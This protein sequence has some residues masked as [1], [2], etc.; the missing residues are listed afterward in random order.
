MPVGATTL[1]GMLRQQAAETPTQAPRVLGVDEWAW[2]RGH[3]YGTILVDLE[4][5]R[6]VDLLP[7]RN[8]DTLVNWF[9]AHPGTEVVSRDRSGTFAD[10][11]RR[12][13]PDA[14]QVANRW[15]LL[16]NCSRA[17]LRRW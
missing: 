6:V 2:R 16:E 17:L 9:R 5:H 13:V 14:I 4:R 10:A 11:T 3:R 8:A 1:L 15:H 7:D 12:A